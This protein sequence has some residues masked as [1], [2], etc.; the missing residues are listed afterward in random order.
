MLALQKNVL[1]PKKKRMQKKQGISNQLDD[2]K[3]V[4]LKEFENRP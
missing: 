1:T 4:Y 2:W 3:I